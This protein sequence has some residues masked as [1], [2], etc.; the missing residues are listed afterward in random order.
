MELSTRFDPGATAKVLLD[1]WQRGQ[2]LESLP[3]GSR[4][5]TLAQGYDAQ[6]AFFDAAGDKRAGWKLG[7]GS[8]AQQ[9]AAGLSRPLIGQL[10]AARLLAPGARVAVPAADALKIECE[11][12]FI[13][14]RDIAPSAG[15]EV[16]PEDIRHMLVTFEVVRSRFADIAAAGWPSF[17]ADNVGFEALVVG[18]PIATG[19]DTALIERLRE[20]LAVRADDDT[21]GAL[22]G[23]QAVDPI[24]AMNALF[25][26]AA[27]RGET[28]RAGEIVSTGTLCQPFELIGT[29]HV[30]RADYDDGRQGRYLEMSL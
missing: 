9:R 5:T 12:A 2:R 8:P 27:E 13:L 10:A 28:L 29:G 11:I 24:T 15:R 20:S 4:P 1:A 30:I 3:E 23:D 17:V 6:A 21:R 26:H 18:E 16:M 19:L 7:V 22:R 25:D 14:A